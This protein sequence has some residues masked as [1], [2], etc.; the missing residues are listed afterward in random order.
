MRGHAVASGDQLHPP[1]GLWAVPEAVSFVKWLTCSSLGAPEAVLLR[2]EGQRAT[3]E[4]LAELGPDEPGTLDNEE[5][6]QL[7][8]AVA[9]ELRKEGL[10]LEA[11]L[12]YR[13]LRGFRPPS[14]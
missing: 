7:D 9:D 11:E 8:R 4:L 14:P 13:R 5:W 1:R 3:Q 2:F 10:G 6:R 12:R